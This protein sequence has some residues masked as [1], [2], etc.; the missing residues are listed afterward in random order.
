MTG[1]AE[2]KARQSYFRSSVF[3]R[4][5]LSYALII[6]V[7]FGIFIGWTLLAYRRETTEL[8]K[9]EWEQRAVTWGTWMDQQLMQAESLCAAVN[10]SESC[11][12]GAADGLCG[13]EDHELAA[14]VQHAGGTEPDQGL[15]AEPAET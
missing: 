12:L 4:M 15:G 14:A 3:K 2:G 13:K 11:T 1:R 9:Q 6:L 10:A 5:F 7:L 8:A